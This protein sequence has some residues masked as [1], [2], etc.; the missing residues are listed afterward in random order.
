MTL[1]SAQPAALA[2][3]AAAVHERGGD[4]R[5]AN[6]TAACDRRNCG[7]NGRRCRSLGKR[8]GKH[9]SINRRRL[10]ESRPCGSAS[11]GAVRTEANL[12]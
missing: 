5:V 11:I 4:A 7:C 9:G 12:R 10:R 3:T 8:M 2:E 1:A 6:D